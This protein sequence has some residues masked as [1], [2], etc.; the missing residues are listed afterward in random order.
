LQEQTAPPA[1]LTHLVLAAEQFRRPAVH[2]S[3]SM[4]QLFPIQP[5]SHTQ[6]EIGKTFPFT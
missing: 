4:L 6:P 5:E 2:S 3:T 1:I